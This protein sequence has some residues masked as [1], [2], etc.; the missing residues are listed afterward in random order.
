MDFE[1]VSIVIC[2]LIRSM[3]IVETKIKLA[4]VDIID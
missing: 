3:D 1:Y 4:S 2:G